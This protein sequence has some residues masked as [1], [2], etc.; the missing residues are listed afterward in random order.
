MKKA[1][2]LLLGCLGATAFAIAPAMG[3]NKEKAKAFIGRNYAHRGLH[4]EDK[5]IPEN[6]LPAFAAACDAGYGMELDVQLSKDGEV[7]VFHDDTLNRV[8]G[9]DARV[10]DLTLAELKELSLCG[11]KETIPLFTEVLSMV[12][13]RE[14]LIVELKTG[15]KNDEL[16]EKTL[17]ILREYKGEYVIE[18]FDPRIVRWFRVNAPD[19][20]RGQLAMKPER[21]DQSYPVW[22]KFALGNCMMNFMARPN[23]IA[24]EIGEYPL[25]VQLEF[26]MGAVKVGWTS[27]E[28]THEADHDMVIFEFYKPERFYR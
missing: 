19:I 18:S 17:A 27:H 3:G 5:Q 23:F 21:Y 10:D 22:Q 4:T 25:L 6:S 7:V 16:C 24:Y 2:K 8:C 1:T 11:T 28:N 12:D 20:I 15:P 9:V 13:G 26:L 14:P